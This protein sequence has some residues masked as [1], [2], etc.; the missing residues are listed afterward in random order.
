MKNKFMQLVNQDD[1]KAELYIYGDI[2]SY[3]W[4]END[5]DANSIRTQLN[6]LKVNEID[7]HINSYG[8]DVFTGIAIYN[9]LKNH[10]AKVNIYVDACACS[11]ASVIAMAGD[12]VYMPKNTFMMIHNCWTSIAGNAK[13]L[14][15]QADDLDVIMNGSI[16]SYLSRVNIPKE[17][18][19]ELLDEET[20]LTADECVEMGFADEVLAL[21]EDEGISQRAILFNLVQKARES[22]EPV[23]QNQTIESLVEEMKVYLQKSIEPKVDEKT[24]KK[25]E[26]ILNGFLNYIERKEDKI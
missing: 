18:L 12:K 21:K 9:M 25:Q 10:T 8:G 17:R 24:N 16:E 20:W 23:Q 13:D 14:R 11:I 6:S 5:V 1:T 15:K 4:W 22:R 3:S 19:I 26:T 7:V 2:V